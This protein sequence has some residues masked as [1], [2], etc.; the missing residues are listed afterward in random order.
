LAGVG[1]YIETVTYVCGGDDTDSDIGIQGG[2][3]GPVDWYI[4]ATWRHEGEAAPQWRSA[5]Y[6]DVTPV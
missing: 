5:L 1:L 2:T 4:G 3:Y 6:G